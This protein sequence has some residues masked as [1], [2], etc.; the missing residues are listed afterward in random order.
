LDNPSALEST[1]VQAS[2][3]VLGHRSAEDRV[4]MRDPAEAADDVAV[5]PG[6]RNGGSPSASQSATARS[7]SAKLSE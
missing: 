2:L 3:L 7:W 4:A 6:M 1:A 5:V